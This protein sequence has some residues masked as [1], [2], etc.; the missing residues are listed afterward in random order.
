VSFFLRC[1]SMHDAVEVVP[2]LSSPES[3]SDF[4]DWRVVFPQLSELLSAWPALA[5]ELSAKS[6]AALAWT[7]WPE[8][9]LYLPAEGHEWDVIPFLH[10]FPADDARASTWIASSCA[11][12]P[13]LARALRRVAGVRTALLSRLGPRTTLTPHTGWAELSNHVL[14]AHV[15]LALPREPGASGVVC[16]GETRTHA[17]G[18][19]LVFDDSVV[20]SGFNA[21]ATD[22]RVVLIVDIVRPPGVRKG[23]AVTG[24][25]RELTNLMDYFRS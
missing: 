7:Q 3:C 14:R 6:P 4:Y 24:A 12:L 11:A 13:L 17:L 8:T 18:E 25:T 1:F 9:S 10:T 15:P 19:A 21:H 23:S 5:A 22:A 20:H 16:G 2:S